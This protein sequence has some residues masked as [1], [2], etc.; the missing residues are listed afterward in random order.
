M[1]VIDRPIRLATILSGRNPAAKA[2]TQIKARTAEKLGIEFEAHDLT[3]VAAA[4]RIIKTLNKGE[5][6][7]GIMIQLPFAGGEADE[8]LCRLIVPAKDADG[9]NPTSGICPATVRAVAAIVE[10]GLEKTGRAGSGQLKMA[11]VGSRG[12][13][14]RGIMHNY[15]KDGRFEL[16][17]M[18]KGELDQTKLQQAEV[19]ISAAGQPDLLGPEMI[20]PGAIVIDVGYPGGD[21][22]SGVR[23]T[24]GFLTPVPGGVGPVTV[25]MLFRNLL[26]LREKE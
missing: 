20:K 18:D 5:R 19:V 9:L 23:E 13:I 8:K 17:G 15:V 2:Y 10:E 1:R 26:E 21:V 16:L 11:V 6:I 12:N 22:Q 14:G 3:E 4:E 7:N 25:A 24:A